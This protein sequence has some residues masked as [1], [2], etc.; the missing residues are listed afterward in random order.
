[1]RALSF[2]FKSERE[3]SLNQPTI[4]TNNQPMEL[5]P[6]ALIALLASGLTLFSGFGLGTLLLPAFALLFPVPIAV[7]ATAVVHLANNLFKLGLL[8]RLADW[9][10]VGRFGSWAALAA[11]LGAW[12]LGAMVRQPP[13]FEYRLGDRVFEVMPVKAVIGGLIMLFAVLELSPRFAR[14]QFDRRWLPLG[15]LLSGF[16][17]GLSGNQGALRSAFL[18]KA[19]LGKEGFVA[20]GAVCAVLVD[21][22]RLAV[23]GSGP[24]LTPLLESEGLAAAVLVASLAAFLGAWLG[25]RML[26]KVTLVLVQRLVAVMMLAVGAGLLLGWL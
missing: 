9:R 2:G 24:I 26:G 11:L 7:A 14:L 17:G 3:R 16:F 15:G 18:I 1:M 8:A 19:G 13:W 23:Y 12:L 10:V 6:I 5:I 20:T 4:Q 22:V 21:A 25:K